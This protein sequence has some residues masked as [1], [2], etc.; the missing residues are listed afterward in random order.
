MNAAQTSL[1]FFEWGRVR[2]HYLAR[3]LDPKQADAKRHELHRKALGRDKSSKGFTNAD[4]DKVIAVFRAEWDGGNLDAQ[5]RQL[6]QPEERR[7]GL[8]ANVATLA[9]ACGID[10]GGDGVE[11]Y[12]FAF[13]RG[14]T[15]ADLDERD[16][17]QVVGILHRRAKQLATKSEDEPF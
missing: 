4:L 2:K 14:R 8:L 9:E 10:G 12:L 11:R 1:Y 13:L 17:Q 5:L 7:R 6:D 16:L 15:L 3:G